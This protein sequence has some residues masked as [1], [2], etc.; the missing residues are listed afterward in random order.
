MLKDSKQLIIIDWASLTL[1]SIGFQ[2]KSKIEQSGLSLIHS[3]LSWRD[4]IRSSLNEKRNL[5]E[6]YTDADNWA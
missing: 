4:S 1:I 5:N 3:F 2:F 6:N